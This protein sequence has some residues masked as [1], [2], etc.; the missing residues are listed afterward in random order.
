MVST[1]LLGST[2]KASGE[3]DKAEGVKTGLPMSPTS[4]AAETEAHFLVSTGVH[5]NG[6]SMK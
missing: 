6:L 3:G 1:D 2:E 4:L 5:L